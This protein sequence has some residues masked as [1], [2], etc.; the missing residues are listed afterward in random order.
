MLDSRLHY[1][2]SHRAKRLQKHLIDAHVLH[3]L[4]TYF[5]LHR[6]YM[7][8]HITHGVIFCRCVE[9][10]V[11]HWIQLPRLDRWKWRWSPTAVQSTSQPYVLYFIPVDMHCLHELFITSQISRLVQ[12]V[13]GI[14]FQMTLH[15]FIQPAKIFFI[16]NQAAVLFTQ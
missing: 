1:I 14:S 6:L 8:S 9:H 11:E 5:R 16:S 10:N 12:Q 3:P 7:S 2:H 4:S 15:Q 13:R